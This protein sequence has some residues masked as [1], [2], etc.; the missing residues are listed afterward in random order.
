MVSLVGQA[1]N[2]LLIKKVSVVS[3]EREANL[4]NVYVLVEND[5][6]TYI[7]KKKPEYSKSTHKVINGKGKYLT[8]GLIDSHVHLA[9][10]PSIKNPADY[11]ELEKKYYEQ[12]GKS[13]LYFGYTTLIDPNNYAPRIVEQVKNGKYHPDIY[14]CSKQLSI[15]NGF[16]MAYEPQEGRF[17]RNPNFL[18]DQY[19][20]IQPKEDFD[21]SLHS[22]EVTVKRIVDQGG[23]CVKT[24]YEDGFGGTED[25]TWRMP[26]LQIIKEVVTASH[27]NNIP[28]LL[29][30]SSYE[31]QRF[32]LQ[33]GVDVIAHGMWHW[34]DLGEF[35]FQSDLPEAHRLLLQEI[36]R[37][38]VGYQPT[39]RVIGAQRD[40]F[41]KSFLND[42]N[43]KHVY[44]EALIDCPCTLR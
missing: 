24:L 1:Q 35:L 31:A 14:T 44:P 18:Y 42:P 36:A 6:I 3:P 32:A 7:G 27:K 21:K 9:N 29:H 17:R 10:M 41:D 40:V 34:G 37:K 19:N 8:P 38:Q 12:L 43:L 28:V 11:P 20:P 22:P 15:A 39:F 4:T 33:S 16:G 25:V 30:A 23:I 26:S 2:N 13:Y 5:V